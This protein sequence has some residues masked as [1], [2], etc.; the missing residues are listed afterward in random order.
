MLTRVRVSSLVRLER[1][2]S[3]RSVV[4]RWGL[5]L[6]FVV[7]TILFTTTSYAADV[8]G[9][10]Q[11]S[12]LRVSWAIGDWG[13]ACGPRPSGGG[14]KGG[15]VTLTS[16]G[17]DFRLSGLGRNYST[18]Q[19]WETMPDLSARGHT[20][21][22]SAIQT[23]CKMPAG[24]PR[25]ATVVTS[26]YP[27][28][29]E[30]YFD[31]T[32]QYQ[33]VV[34]K[35][36]CTASVRRTRVLTRIVDEPE[37]PET[38]PAETKAP[39]KP[40]TTAPQPKQPTQ[41]TPKATSPPTTPKEREVV[42]AI[43]SFLIPERA[44]RCEQVG[45][46]VQLEVTP[47]MKLMRLG[48]SFSFQAIARDEAG[49]RVDIETSWKLVEGVS[50]TLTKNG[51]LVIPKNGNTGSLELE[52]RVEDKTVVVGAKVV[53]D[54]E[55]EQLLAG[56]EYGVLGESLHSATVTLSSSHV[57]FESQQEDDQDETSLLWIVA[58]LLVLVAGAAVTMVIKGA[59]A[60]NPAPAPDSNRPPE[61]KGSLPE[62]LREAEPI[63]RG[64]APESKEPEPPARLCPVCGKSYQD[65]TMFCV[66]DG[67]RLL[68]SN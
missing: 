21:G 12:S 55:F 50:A 47:K 39:E 36:N 43:V 40:A 68:R 33:F 44:A 61:T 22:S 19:C 7:G 5:G 10:W 25:Q 63:E 49:C 42:P 38:E 2:D 17:S 46:A 1:F 31:E 67:A 20:A 9:K 66:D 18:T 41:P 14:E 64:A 56:G 29:D 35:S 3:V 59:K 57:E 23:T 37:A 52:A 45:K 54:E 28:G 11:A 32:G 24:D 53:S 62:E 65:G 8:S 30:I 6:F 34:S 27:R 58:G 48:E 15:V 4:R 51:T 13:N 16:S 60:P 26:W